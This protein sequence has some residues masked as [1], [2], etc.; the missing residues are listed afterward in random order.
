MQIL[1]N[2]KT[3]TKLMALITLFS[4]IC[5]M[6]G[7]IGIGNMSTFFQHGKVMHDSEMMG[8]MYAEEIDAGILHAIRAEKNFILASSSEGRTRQVEIYKQSLANLHENIAKAKPL[9]RTEAGKAL[10]VKLEKAVAEWEPVSSRVMELAASEAL[11]SERKSVQ[12]SEGEARD[13]VQ[14][15]EKAAAEVV[16]R[17]LANAGK[18]DKETEEAFVMS[19]A[20]MIALIVGGIGLGI[21]AGLLISGMITGPLRQAVAV[22]EA[23]AQGDLTQTIN[24]DR[25]DEMGQLADA[26]N[27]M[28]QNLRGMI[29]QTADIST[30]IA[31]AS[32]QLHSTSTQIATGAEEVASQANTVATASEEMSATSTDIASNCSMAAEAS[33]QTANSASAG[34]QVVN[35]T[36]TG[37]NIIAERVRQTS[38]TVEALGSRSDQIGQIVGTI[39]DIADQTNLLALNAAIEAARAGEQGRGFAVVADEVRALA[40]RTTKATREIGEMIKAIQ[41][42]TQEAVKA[43]EVGVS[44]VEKGAVS[45]Q[46]SGQALE[47]ILE[48]IN[49][50]TMQVN[51][52]ATAAEE[53]TATTSEV[54]SN[55]QQ[56]T[57]VV[58]QTACGADETATAASQLARQAQE[59]QNLVSRFRLA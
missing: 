55:I 54:T 1:H 28:V 41:K 58:H 30:G 45:S 27:T 25:K 19:R 53:Q 34:A 48:R 4:S 51:Q 40:E 26:M 50:V 21:A 49:E 9:F 7:A 17:K 5:I 46:K 2:F 57:E 38:L 32:N 23:L 52:I 3:K 39:E 37:M 20:I 35:E 47:E 14:A 22:T 8:L 10:I 59:L 56:I 12:L 29:T 11:S 24:L 6:L 36:I 42:E 31:S 44:E 16:K 18:L 33:R 15:V 13:K 43:M